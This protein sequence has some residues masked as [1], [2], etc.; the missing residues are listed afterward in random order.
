MQKELR[1]ERK[2]A[3]PLA[4]ELQRTKKL[5]ERLRRQSHVPKEERQKLIEE[6][7]GIITGRVKEFVFKHD[8]VRV[9]QTAIKYA[10]PER[11]KAIAM[12][13]KGTYAELAEGRYSKFL[14]GKLMVQ[15]DKEV[16]DMIISEF[17]GKVKKLIN[18]A[19]ASWI[20]DDIYRVI[21]TKEQKAILLREW[22]GPEFAL[23]N[24]SQDATPDADLSKILEAE[25]AKRSP[26]MS[27][28]FS[29][30]NSLIQKKLTGFTMLHDAMLQ[31]LLNVKR[32]SESWNE[33]FETVKGDEAGDLL[34]NMAF[35]R[36]GSRIVALL[37]AYGS[38]KDRK[39]MLKTFKDTVALMS[40]DQFAH[41]VLLTIYEVIDDTKLSS[42]AVFPELLGES[43]DTMAV[44]IA[45][46]ATNPNA[47]VSLLYL[48]D[49]EPK[50][51]YARLSPALLN[52]D[53]EILNEVFNIRKETSKKEPEARRN[54]LVKFLSPLLLK[55][56][57][58]AAS[59]LLS[60][61][62][63]C[64]IVS[65]ALF[66]GA[67]DKSDALKAVAAAAGGDPSEEASPSHVSQS[68][69]GKRLLKA[70]IAG[71]HFDKDSGA[72][73]KV[74]P[75]LGFAD[76]LYPAIKDHALGWATGPAAFV[77]VGLLE[78]DDFSS[79]TE[80]TKL[81]KANVS[82]IRQAATEETALQKAAREAETQEQGANNTGKKTKKNSTKQEKSVGNAGAKLLLEKL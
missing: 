76:I 30:I 59:T 71:G 40:G 69:A 21:A 79:T 6:L 41:I 62:T 68:P 52:G 54:E 10:T 9:V 70:L 26:I 14:I 35:T 28:L 48:F 42:K 73:K 82:A 53:M 47:L 60:S 29:L 39:Q 74:E 51:A 16:Q 1:Q 45:A 56:V 5:W 15:N 72:V 32:D 64:Q 19:E 2:A 11:R 13:L 8:S 75:P 61:P 65:Q 25:P 4:D 31:Y 22:Y 77:I 20:L 66:S 46:A 80:L 7:F 49:K 67:G 57:A 36:S 37:L 3:K 24:Q 58:A 18:H 17:Y 63:G 33:F 78:A 27:Y 81:L 12:E 55:A 38:A 44:N 43:D 23:M 50:A 34:K